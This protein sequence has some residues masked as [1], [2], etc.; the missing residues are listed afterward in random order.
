MKRINYFGVAI[1]HVLS[2]GYFNAGK[3]VVRCLEVDELNSTDTLCDSSI[4]SILVANEA[5][6][7]GGDDWI[8]VIG[9]IWGRRIC[10][11]RLARV[12]SGNHVVEDSEAIF[13]S[14]VGHVVTELTKFGV[15]RA[16]VGVKGRSCR[17]SLEIKPESVIQ[18]A[19]T[20]VSSE[21]VVWVSDP[22][23]CRRLVSV[24]KTV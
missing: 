22:E 10:S 3:T 16:Y 6:E 2:Q 7:E 11:Q 9:I 19:G 17:G 18:R 13:T 24:K 15:L 1:N 5:I 8:V 14:R 4:T 12:S 20:M 21:D 23:A